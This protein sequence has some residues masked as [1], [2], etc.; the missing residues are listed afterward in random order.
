MILLKKKL[1]IHKDH[2]L[3]RKV[4]IKRNE[5]PI[6]KINN[7]NSNNNKSSHRNLIVK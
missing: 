7:C 4:L 5:I 3:M 1:I 6:K 2:K